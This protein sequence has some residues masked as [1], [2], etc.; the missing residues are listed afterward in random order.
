M[1]IG[2]SEIDNQPGSSIASGSG[3]GLSLS[4]QEKKSEGGG[5]GEGGQRLHCSSGQEG[6]IH[7]MV[8]LV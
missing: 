4:S 7:D 1:E 8:K 6:T 2:A 3:G 5:V